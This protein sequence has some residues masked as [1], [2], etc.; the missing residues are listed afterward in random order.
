MKL[1]HF[2][3]LIAKFVR[4]AYIGVIKTEKADQMPVKILLYYYLL[5]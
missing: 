5:R 2:N 4:C 3:A 1:K